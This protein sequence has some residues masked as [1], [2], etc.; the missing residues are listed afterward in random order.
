MT[1]DMVINLSKRCKDL[2]GQR[3]GRLVA[4]RPAG[5]DKYHAV[6]W[7]CQ[8]DCGKKCIVRGSSLS[9]GHSR[10]CGC[11]H[12]EEAANQKR[13]HGMSRSR[14]Y[15]SWE[16]MIRRC[17]NPKATGFELY[18]GRGISVCE[19]WHK[20]ENF[21]EDMGERPLGKTIDRSDNEGNYEP[22]NCKWST[23][24]EQNMNKRDRKD[25]KWFLG[26][27]TNTGEFE[28]NNNQTEFE[29][30]HQL[31]QDSVR[32]CLH[33]KQKQTHGWEFDYLPFQE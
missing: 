7:E 25:Q 14:T 28:E 2:T 4:L 20:F 3:F 9:D 31:P 13:T 19:R 29:R 8:C 18:G 21:Y 6:L 15:I 17:E 11:L 12:K 30:E 16:G 24:H 5:R 10:S 33:G 1:K 22:G 27:D 26:F 32:A 23:P